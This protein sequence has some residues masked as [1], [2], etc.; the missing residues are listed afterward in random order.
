ML[1]R[2]VTPNLL[3]GAADP[4]QR[5]SSRHL[6]QPGHCR[7]PSTKDLQ[8]C[9]SHRRADGHEWEQVEIPE[10]PG[11]LQVSPMAGVHSSRHT[12]GDTEMDGT[13][14]GQYG[15]EQQ[16]EEQE[17]EEGTISGLLADSLTL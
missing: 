12:D 10:I 11:A 1:V 16:E 13:V 3:P 8:G 17:W 14:D 15:H 4:I 2:S 9:A 6:I 5:R 7:L